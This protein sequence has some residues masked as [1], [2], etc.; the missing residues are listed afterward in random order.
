MNLELSEFTNQQ[1]LNS[2]HL[3]WPRF[4]LDFQIWER[5]TVLKKKFSFKWTQIPF[6]RNNQNKVPNAQ[7]IYTFIIKPKDDRY[8]INTSYILYI[9]QSNNLKQRFGKYFNYKSSN[10]PSDLFRRIMVLIWEEYL[11]FNYFVTENLASK[12]LDNLEYDLIDTII[13]PMNNQFRA[14]IIKE[15]V[16]LFRR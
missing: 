10:H 16:K 5:E 14:D 15:Q 4:C 6:R 12:D 7:G 9:G 1:I 13:P 8:N 2:Y 3:R 11:L